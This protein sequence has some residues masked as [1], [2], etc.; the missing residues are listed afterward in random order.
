[1]SFGCL[2][3]YVSSLSG[4]PFSNAGML[5]TFQRYQTMIRFI[6]EHFLSVSCVF[7]CEMLL[8]K[9]NSK[10]TKNDLTNAQNSFTMPDWN[11]AQWCGIHA[12]CAYMEYTFTSISAASEIVRYTRVERE[13]SGYSVLLLVY[14]YRIFCICLRISRT[15]YPIQIA[16]LSLSM[17]VCI[18]ERVRNCPTTV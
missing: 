14:L 6:L 15:F 7:L 3:V 16:F 17:C 2:C 10:F 11:G 4:W 9:I 18:W 5:D 8:A 13:R 12:I 1:M